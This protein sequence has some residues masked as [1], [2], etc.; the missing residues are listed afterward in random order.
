MVIYS[1]HVFLPLQTVLS[2]KLYPDGQEHIPPL[3]VGLHIWLQL[4]L[5]QA[6]SEKKHTLTQLHSE[7]PKLY[8]ILVFLSATV[9]NIQ[10]PSTN[11]VQIH[12][13]LPLFTKENNFSD[14]IFPPI[15]NIVFS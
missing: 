12:F 4:W 6:V 2:V 7:R 3:G 5:L 13:F 14:F 1:I 8:T 9:L 11:K 10:K 15:I